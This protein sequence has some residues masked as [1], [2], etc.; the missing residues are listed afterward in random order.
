MISLNELA[1]KYGTDKGTTKHGYCETYEHFLGVYEAPKLLEIG[2]F[3]GASLRMWADYFPFGEIL[4]IDH[5][6]D[7][8][9]V[10]LPPNASTAV[11]SQED[12][13][14][15]MVAICGK[16]PFD[17]IIDDGSHKWDHQQLS[18]MWLWPYVAPGGVYVIEDLHTSQDERFRGDA[19]ENTHEFIERWSTTCEG[20][21]VVYHD[22]KLAIIRRD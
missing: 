20:R 6:A 17:I 2:I 19:C 7:R 13:E 15:L 14:S 11:A 18:L 5:N 21:D 1:L 3:F 12:H 22:E 9:N 4:G 16:G 10:E 8:A